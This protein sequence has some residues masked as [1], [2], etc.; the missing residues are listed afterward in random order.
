MASFTLPQR[1]ILQQFDNG[2]L[3]R[4]FNKT[5]TEVGHGRLWNTNG[6]FLDIGGSTGG[7]ARRILDKWQPPDWRD[8]LDAFEAPPF[9]R[10]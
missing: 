9:L 10:R 8:F 1:E 4:D 2:D 7:A 3:I 5:V 6:Q